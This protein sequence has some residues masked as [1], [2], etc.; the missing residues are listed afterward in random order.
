MTTIQVRIDEKTKRSAKK[1]LNTLGLDLSAGIKLFLNQ[2]NIRK[3]MPF[4]L[5][6]E[7]GFTAKEEKAILK[8]EKEALAGKNVS[9]PMN[10]KE[11]VAYL[12][13]LM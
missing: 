9:H 7:N 10:R 3:G 2:V 12:K 5:L 6:T 11:M 1:I 8:A 13:K 4:E